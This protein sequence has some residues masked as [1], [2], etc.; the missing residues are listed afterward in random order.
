MLAR[1]LPRESFSSYEDFKTN[2]RIDIPENFNF[3]YDIIDEWAKICPEKTALLWCNDHDD[4]YRIS[5]EELS[6]LSNRFAAVLKA[7]RRP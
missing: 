4:E 7:P 3:G 1:F 2:F 5:W 6:D